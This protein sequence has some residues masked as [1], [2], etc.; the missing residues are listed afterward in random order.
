MVRANS[1]SLALRDCQCVPVSSGLARRLTIYADYG[2][3]CDV[4]NSG[5]VLLVWFEGLQ[6][7]TDTFSPCAHAVSVDMLRR[8]LQQLSCKFHERKAVLTQCVREGSFSVNCE[9]A[10][11]QQY[12]PTPCCRRIWWCTRACKARESIELNQRLALVEL[13]A[14]SAHLLSQTP[15]LAHAAT[16]LGRFKPALTILSWP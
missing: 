4:S 11:L 7:G 6:Q 12:P 13:H 10:T 15:V 2:E 5:L 3:L 14:V 1:G 8:L 16:A 9:H